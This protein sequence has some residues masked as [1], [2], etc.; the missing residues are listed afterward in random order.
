PGGDIVPTQPF[1]M[2]MASAALG[3]LI[4]IEPSASTIWP[5]P[6]DLTHSSASQ[7]RPSYASPWKTMPHMSLL[8]AARSLS[9]IVLAVSAGSFHVVG[10]LA[11]YLSSRSLR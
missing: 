10:T 7:V 4:E 8:P 5:P 3:L 11:P 2:S 9:M 6:L 1:T